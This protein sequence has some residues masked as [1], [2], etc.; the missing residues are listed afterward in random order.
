[1]TVVLLIALRSLAKLR[2]AVLSRLELLVKLQSLG[3]G[4]RFYVVIA[5]A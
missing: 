5:S 1:M 2:M 3:P 4:S